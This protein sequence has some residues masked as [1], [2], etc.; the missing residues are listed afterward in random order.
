MNP[1]YPLVFIKLGGSL[2]TDK[3]LANTARKDV[4]K[5]IGGEIKHALVENPSLRIIIGHGSGSFGH[6]TGKKYGTRDGVHSPEQWQGFVNVWK[7]ARNLNQIVIKA[8]LRTSLPVMAFPP[9]AAVIADNRS[10]QSWDLA[11][12]RIAVSQGII[13]VIAGDVILDQSLGGTILSTEELFLHLARSFQPARI[14]LAGIEDGV[15]ADFPACSNLIP[16]ITPLNYE[17]VKQ[18]LTGSESV[19]VTGGMAEKVATMLQIA[20]EIPELKISIFSGN[21]PDTIYQ[22]LLDNPEGTL[23]THS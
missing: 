21:K 22:G 19:D 3:N 1:G 5:R 14:L 13:P 8:L 4:L 20:R 16:R 6:W 9:S 2:I 10:I 18:S 17:Q 7:S 15:W 23:I 11:P 12:M